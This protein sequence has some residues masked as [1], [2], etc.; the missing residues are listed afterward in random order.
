[1]A[2]QSTPEVSP[3]PDRG[4]ILPHAEIDEDDEEEDEE[5]EGA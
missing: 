5:D 4:W 2:I 3:Y 1:M